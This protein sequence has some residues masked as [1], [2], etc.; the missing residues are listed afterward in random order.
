MANIRLNRLIARLNLIYI[1]PGQFNLIKYA[2]D[3][4]E[5]QGQETHSGRL[6]LNKGIRV[7]LA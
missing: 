1:I 2:R 4:C 7:W 3:Y 5:Y 6:V